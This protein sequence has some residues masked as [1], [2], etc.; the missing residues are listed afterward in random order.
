M[1]PGVGPEHKVGG[2]ALWCVVSRVCCAVKV[3]GLL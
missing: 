3:K 2:G 1:N